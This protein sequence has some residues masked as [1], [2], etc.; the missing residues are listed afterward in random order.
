MST[1]PSPLAMNHSRFVQTPST[2]L[3][4]DVEDFVHWLGANS[5]VEMTGAHS[6]R[7]LTRAALAGLLG[8]GMD[9][10][11]GG[12]GGTLW[13]AVLGV[14]SVAQQSLAAAWLV[15]SQ[16]SAI[17]AMALGANIGLRD[18]RLPE[19]LDGSR[20]ALVGVPA[21]PLI[22]RD[23]GRGWRLTGTLTTPSK[24]ETDE[25]LLLVPVTLGDS[26]KQVMLA[27]VGEQD[28][29]RRDAATTVD[30]Q[31][32]F[33]R[34]DE[35]LDEDAQ[36]LRMRL[37]PTLIALHSGVA[38]GSIWEAWNDSLMTAADRAA[39]SQACTDLRNQLNG[40]PSTI[41]LEAVRERLFDIARRC[42]SE[43]LGLPEQ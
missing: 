41:T 4:E 23:T 17:G 35:L 18:Y 34:E 3:S 19:L 30:L 39:V 14:A 9:R 6:R 40:S 7:V 15:C 5:G 12:T 31:N 33:F 20:H 32:V 26:P 29:I 43:H 36:A 13:D 22:G 10:E 16:R 38:L 25:Y 37:Q 2:R 27:L 21:S 1:S 11:I 28:G 24:V 8:I 42:A